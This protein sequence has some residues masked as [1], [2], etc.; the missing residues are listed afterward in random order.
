MT[1]RVMV[2]YG[3]RPEAIKLAPVVRELRASEDLE[4]VVVVTGQHREMLDQVN[5]FFGIVPDVDL[6]LMSHGSSVSSVARRVLAA[7]EELLE[8][9]E[10]DAVVVQGDTTSAFAASLAAFLA[11]VPVVHV[12]AGTD[13]T[14]C[15]P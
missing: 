4:P 15:P 9:Q 1:A 8:E 5:S 3:T 11:G 13:P 6:D 2:V 14:E 7:M 10:P 12:E